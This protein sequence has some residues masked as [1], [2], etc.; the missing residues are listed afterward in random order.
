MYIGKQPQIGNYQACDSITATAT[1]TFNLTVGNVAVSP[2]SAHHCLV[3]LN[4]I[5]QAPISSYTI[6]GS[7]IVF[8][9]A[10]TTSDSIDF[11]TILG[12]TLDTGTPSDSTVTTAKLSGNLVTPGTLDVNGNELI[13]DADADTSITADTDD[14]IHFKAGGSDRV[15]IDTSG[16]LLVGKTGS[17]AGVA[18]CQIEAVGTGAFT[19][20]SVFLLLLN[21]LTDDGSL[22]TLRQAGTEEGT[23]SVS[24]STVS[25]NAFTGSHWS[26][27][28]DN[29]KPTILKGTVLETLDEMVDW[30]NLEFNDNKGNP[31]KIPH[32]LTGS[33]SAGDKITYDHNG[34]DYEATIVKEDDIKHVQS[35]ISTTSEAKNVYGVFSAWDEDGEGYNDFYVASVGSFVVRIKQGETVAKGDLLQ[36]NGDGTAKVQSDDNVK[37]SSFAKVLSNTKIETYSDGSYIVP[38]SLMC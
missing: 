6:V 4:G 29:S 20:A 31:Q 37:S 24:G 26:R 2:I 8:A 15:T 35:K 3:S 38:C 14:T 7:T 11:I 30:Y 16:N 33:Q 13:L 5:L 23:I 12:N 9:S 27:L 10:L 21:R 34:T 1:D 28:S 18:G 19:R 36:S 17:D 32:V 22:I 25:Y